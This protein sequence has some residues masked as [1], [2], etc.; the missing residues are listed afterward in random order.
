MSEIRVTNVLGENGNSPVNFTKGI[1]MSGIVTATSFVPT[2]GQL[3]HRN[4]IINGACNIAQR[5]VSA[6]SVSGQYKT[7]DRF[8]VN[9]GG[10]DEDPTEAQ[11]T[12]STS[13]TPY[14][15]GFRKSFHITNGNQTSGAG[16]ADYV[17]PQYK[18]EAQDIAN[19]GWNYTDSNSFIT[20][21][22]WVKASVAGDYTLNMN[23]HDGTPYRYLMEYSLLANTWKHV[24][25]KIPGNSNLTV[26][27]DNGL[28]LQIMWYPFLGSN[29]IQADQ[30]NNWYASSNGKY[31]TVSTTNWWTTNDATWEITG[32]QLEVGDTA[33]TFE[34]RSHGDELQRCQRYCVVYGGSGS[35]HLGTAS[36]YNST[37][38]NLS[39]HL[40]VSMRDTPNTST[41][42]TGGNWLQSYVGASGNNSNAT[43]SIADM[44]EDHHTIRVY[45]QNAHSGLSAGQALWIHTLANAKLI[46]SAEL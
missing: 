29:Y 19:S 46:L 1:N 32:V 10:E 18:I 8:S 5:G 23:T 43:I 20:L 45:L 34:H 26:N 13:D 44:D 2:V 37:N 40:P 21:S 33:T 42:T 12:L 27:N 11:H 36:A 24:V 7:V 9:Y 4:I 6:T 3:S 22:F 30:E 35:R 25:F 15:L 31:G 14:T 17:Q 28:G 38:L 16:A 39:I 41:V